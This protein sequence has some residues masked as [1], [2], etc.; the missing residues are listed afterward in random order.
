MF[1]AQEHDQPPPRVGLLSSD[2]VAADQ[3]QKWLAAAGMECMNVFGAAV[4]R[5]LD[6]LVIDGRRQPATLAD[7]DPSLDAALLVVGT[8]SPDKLPADEVLPADFSPREL[9]LT[10]RLL[11]RIARLRR[12]DSRPTHGSHSED[13]LALRDEL[14]GLPG[15]RAWQ[16]EL[17]A[18]LAASAL[19]QPNF[20]LAIFDLDHFKQVNDGWGLAAGDRVL[21]AAG[22]A[23]RRSLRQRDFVARLGGDEFGVLLAGLGSADAH[24]VVERVRAG[25]P[26]IIASLAPQVV[27]AT[28]GFV[29]PKDPQSSSP[30]SLYT[31]AAAALQ[32]AKQKGGGRTEQAD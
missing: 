25:L 8:E 18:R 4:E 13:D 31:A 5:N 19:G 2:S 20:C 12:Q 14:T 27:G 6:V 3:W 32:R 11:A 16:R 23:L 10:C 17:E 15:R 28:A 29:A 9:V 22:E 26:A 30:A 21:C 7:L 24:G 1:P